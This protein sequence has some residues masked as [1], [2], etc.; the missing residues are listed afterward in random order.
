MAGLSR[1]FIYEFRL[2]DKQAKESFACDAN[3][4]PPLFRSVKLY[5]QSIERNLRTVD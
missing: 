1:V 3:Y 2:S 4:T 5:D